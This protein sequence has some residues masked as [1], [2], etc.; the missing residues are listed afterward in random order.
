M[1]TIYECTSTGIVVWNVEKETLKTYQLM[2]RTKWP[3][4]YRLHKRKLDRSMYGG[5][6]LYIN[7]YFTKDVEKAV[8]IMREHRGRVR[9]DFEN[10]IAKIGKSI[11]DAQEVRKN[12]Q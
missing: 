3:I 5:I 8:E 6:S 12:D 2:R 4:F 7:P 10:K 9:D 1:E 11:K